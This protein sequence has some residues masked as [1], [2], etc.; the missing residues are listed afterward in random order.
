MAQDE[1]L[2]FIRVICVIR[3]QNPLPFA[4]EPWPNR[5]IVSGALIDELNFRGLC[6]LNL[7]ALASVDKPQIM[8]E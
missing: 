1:R 2:V 6:F 8:L 4:S 5:E 3:G 7:T